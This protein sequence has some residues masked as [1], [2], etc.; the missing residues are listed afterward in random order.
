MNFH[1]FTGW[2]YEKGL[3]SYFG[4]IFMTQKQ[5]LHCDS[6]YYTHQHHSTLT[7][8][9]FEANIHVSVS[10]PGRKEPS[11]AEIGRPSVPAQNREDGAAWNGQN[12]YHA[13]SSELGP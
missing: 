11:P 5:I 13:G 1:M 7:K 9:C 10:L 8:A 3:I 6:N 4:C 2:G 12:R